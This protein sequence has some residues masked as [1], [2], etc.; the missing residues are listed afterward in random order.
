VSESVA[1]DVDDVTTAGPL[2]IRARTDAE[3]ARLVATVEPVAGGPGTLHPL[4][5]TVDGWQQ[6]SLDG[7]TAQDYRITVRAPGVHPVTDVASVV[8]LDEIA[9]SVDV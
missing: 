5:T 3:G 7:L 6:T 4:A 2:V 8:D 9:R 1:V